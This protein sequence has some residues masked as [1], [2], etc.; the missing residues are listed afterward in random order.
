MTANA[1]PSGI[2]PAEGTVSVADG[3]TLRT[4][5]WASEGEPWAV[6]LVVHGLGEHGGRYRT[7]AG[8]LTAAGIDVLAYDQRGFGGSAGV[9]GYVDRFGQLHDD[10]AVVTI[11]RG[12]RF[13]EQQH[14][15]S[16]DHAVGNVDALLLAARKSGR[17]QMPKVLVQVQT[18]E[19][20]CGLSAGVISMDTKAT[21]RISHDVE[22][23]DTRNHTKKL[24]D[25]A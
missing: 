25:I 9:R 21:Q 12:G 10:L 18:F 24:R 7:V 14:W 4:F 3:T 5:H 8:A 16:G 23:G 15:R 20:Q 19:P 22:C 6:A 1:I 17:R 11:E 2:V 13:I